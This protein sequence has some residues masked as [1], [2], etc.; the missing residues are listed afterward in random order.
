M[1][2]F[3]RATI[4]AQIEVWR[5]FAKIAK[6]INQMCS[7]TNSAISGETERDLEIGSRRKNRIAK[8]TNVITEQ[9]IVEA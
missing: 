7:E 3:P 4:P 9:Q 8:Y 5:L 6:Q 1:F 2:Y